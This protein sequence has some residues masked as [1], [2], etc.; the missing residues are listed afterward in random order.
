MTEQ[1][2]R[3]AIKLRLDKYM[4]SPQVEVFA[5]E[6]QSRQVAVVGMVQKPGLYTLSSPNDT[7]LSM[8]SR[9]GGTNSDSSQRILL[10]P[11]ESGGNANPAVMAA[12]A[13]QLGNGAAPAPVPANAAAQTAAKPAQPEG[14]TAEQATATSVPTSYKPQPT[15]AP[16]IFGHV[17]PIVID[18]ATSEGQRALSLP[19]RPGDVIIV[20]AVGQVMVKGWVQNPG[21]FKITPGM[22]VLGAVAAAGGQMFSSSAEV[23]RTS[24]NG[25]QVEIPID[26]SSIEKGSAADFPVQSGDVIIVQRS[27]VGAV[28]YALYTLLSKFGTGVYPA[29]P[30]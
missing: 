24:T 29:I 22:T 3:D 4:Y 16:S 8:I 12:A 6:Y 10:V 9:A 18:L 28:P 7:I 1:G 30:F 11:A 21:A 26:L 23:L 17:S 2:V 20:P 14:A 15:D 25:G 13:S 5:K 19:A 27:V